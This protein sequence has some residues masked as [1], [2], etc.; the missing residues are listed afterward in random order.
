MFE[1]EYYTLEAEVILKN[2]EGELTLQDLVALKI[3]EKRLVPE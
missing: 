2:F 1:H 3:T